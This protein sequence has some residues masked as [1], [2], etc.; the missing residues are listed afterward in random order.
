MS[1][2]ENG[3]TDPPLGKEEF[4]STARAGKRT[5]YKFWIPEQAQDFGFT[6][7]RIAI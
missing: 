6:K 1:Y 2:L 7:D 5:S 3:L 4:K